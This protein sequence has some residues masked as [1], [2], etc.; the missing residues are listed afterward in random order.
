[1]SQLAL[2]LRPAA[3]PHPIAGLEYS[4]YVRAPWPNG[5]CVTNYYLGESQELAG[6][7]YADEA[8]HKMLVVSHGWKIT[9]PTS[10]GTNSLEIDLGRVDYSVAERRLFE[11]ATAARANP[12]LLW[13]HRVTAASRKI[14]KANGWWRDEPTVPREHAEM[15]DAA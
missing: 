1:M 11:E 15:G 9:G 6:F 8:G 10:G 7:I 4:C 14:A 12:K 5:D 13:S 3:P 2:D